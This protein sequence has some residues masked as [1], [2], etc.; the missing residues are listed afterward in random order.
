MGKKLVVHPTYSHL[1]KVIENAL[2]DFETSKGKLLWNER[3]TIKV[4]QFDGKEY[5]VKYFR[6]PHLVNQLMYRFFRPSKAERSYVHTRKLLEQNINAPFPLAYFEK[7]TALLF[8]DSF[9]VSELVASNL[10]YRELIHDTNYPDRVEIL[11]QFTR[12]TFA[13]HEA[14][15]E[16]LDH[17]P[18]NTLIKKEGD[19]YQFYLV[20]VNR[21][22]F[23]TLNLQ[24]RVDNFARLTTDPAMIR[25]MAYEYA[26]LVDTNQETLFLMMEQAV[27]A[28]QKKFQRRKQWKRK[29][30]FWKSK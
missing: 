18:G 26:V 4:M 23:G 20:D 5:A 30:K 1:T 14:G 13:M 25:I 17:S 9:F 16:F 15:I 3:N 28:F 8:K 29:Y 2:E 7:T 6:V 11:K 19:R 24:Q 21:M 22:R 12:F 10:T 27:A